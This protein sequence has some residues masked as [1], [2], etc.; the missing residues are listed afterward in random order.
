MAYKT[1]STMYQVAKETEF[2]KGAVF[3]EAD[4]VEVT[5]DSS[6]KPEI[7]NIERKTI[8]HSYI[9]SPSL[10]GKEYG[11][12]TL[13]FE[14]LPNYDGTNPATL[15]GESVLEVA[16]GEV[17]PAGTGTGCVI[18]SSAFNQV[19]GTVT[20]DAGNTGDGTLTFYPEYADEDTIQ[21]EIWTVECVDATTAGAEEW[22]VTG[23]ISGLN[24][25][26][27]F[28]GKYYYNGII[29]FQI[30]AGTT[31]FI[32]GD[33]FTIDITENVAPEIYSVTN[34]GN[35][36]EGSL[37]KL[38]RP[39]GGEQ[40][41]AAKVMY[42]CDDTDSRALTLKG[43][44]PNNVKFTF[45]VADICTVSF[46]IG[47][48]SFETEQNITLPSYS[49]TEGLP[50]VGKNAYF[51]VDDMVKEA[52]DI[53]ITIENKVSDRE[54]I[55][56]SGIAQ[57]VVTSKNIKGSFTITFTD[58]AELNTFKN[59]GMGKVFLELKQVL[60]TT[61]DLDSA[62]KFAVYAPYIKYSSVAVED[63]DGVLVN[64]IEFEAYEEPT[65]KE[66]IL[67]GYENY[68]IPTAIGNYDLLG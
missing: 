62:L 45:P 17:S 51:I 59:N 49:A 41:L 12:G 5:S 33:K 2:N 32:V 50:Y 36:S 1:L 29:S 44:V 9:T 65:T 7:D 15:M 34:A 63:D 64:K 42:G 39:C 54:A 57:K 14:L 3:T 43:L 67:I 8:N 28:T 60:S 52:K 30:E 18:R 22:S 10:S 68:K 11:S 13:A 55:T 35:T 19:E 4:V 6:L 61:N 47:A 25:L 24:T 23:S 20:A 56:S 26:H 38:N 40:S 66:A 53:E 37:F 21:T 46:D 48:S 16:L 31:A 58:W 27:S